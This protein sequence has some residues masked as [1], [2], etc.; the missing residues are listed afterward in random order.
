MGKQMV[1]LTNEGLFAGTQQITTTAAPIN[2][3]I[4]CTEVIV[5]ASNNNGQNNV[6]V[7]SVNHQTFELAAGAAVTIPIDATSKVYVVAAAG[8]LTV[9]WLAVKG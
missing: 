3:D 8:T 7:G 1:R 4:H 9:N 2:R 6:L 5:Q